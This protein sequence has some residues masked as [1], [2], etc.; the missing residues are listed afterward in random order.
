MQV[1]CE[2]YALLRVELCHCPQCRTGIAGVQPALLFL[3]RLQSTFAMQRFAVIDNSNR[4]SQV[5]TSYRPQ[6]H[7]HKVLT[8]TTVTTTGL[9]TAIAPTGLLTPPVDPA[10]GC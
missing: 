2:T 9:L 6:Q 7:Y 10:P 1:H 3:L 8:H 4:Q 5:V